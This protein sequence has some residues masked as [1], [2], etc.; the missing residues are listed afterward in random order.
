MTDIAAGAATPSDLFA[1]TSKAGQGFAWSSKAKPLS[2][3]AGW[4]KSGLWLFIA[5]HAF[6]ILLLVVLLWTFSVWTTPGGLENPQAALL[7]VIAGGMAPFVPFITVTP[8]VLCIFLYLRF[9]Y[10]AARNLELSRARGLDVSP[11]WAV[12]WSF[13]PLANLGMIYKVMEQIWQASADPVKNKISAPV[14]LGWWWG[15]WIAGGIIARISD[16][17]VAA[18]FGEDPTTFFDQFMP[19]ASLAALASATA[20]VSTILLMSIVRQVAE[21]QETLRSTAVFED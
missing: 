6:N 12:G 17:L 2:G 9:V 14:S 5:A 21:A 4:L 13:V 19:G 15:L 3:L 1:T 11:G 16:A 8:F 18:D 10:S 7:A 20:V